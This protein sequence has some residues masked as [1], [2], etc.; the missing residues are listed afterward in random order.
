MVLLKALA[1]I[2]EDTRKVPKSEDHPPESL[3]PNGFWLYIL[4]VQFNLYQNITEICRLFSNK[5]LGVAIHFILYA[6]HF[7]KVCQLE[8]KVDATT[9]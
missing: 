8:Q 6:K 9:A 5:V 4:G 2:P 1:M 7:A 3:H